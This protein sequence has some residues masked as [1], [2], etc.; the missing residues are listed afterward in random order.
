MTA[1]CNKEE[2]RF[3]IDAS[4]YLAFTKDFE[5]ENRPVFPIRA[6]YDM[7]SNRYKNKNPTPKDGH[8]ITFTG[9]LTRILRDNEGK[10][11]RFVADIHQV[12]FLGQAPPPPVPASSSTLNSDSAYQLYC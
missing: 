10:V 3:D 11:T 7:T 12:V 4:Q 2:A 1:N 6:N 5:A 9:F 8:Y